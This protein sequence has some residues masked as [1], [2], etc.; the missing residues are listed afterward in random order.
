MNYK[1]GQIVKYPASAGER[2]GIKDWEIVRQHSHYWII[3]EKD[4]NSWTDLI[5]SPEG[6]DKYNK[7]GRNK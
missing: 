7:Q 1:I 2:F 3:K 4:N 5:T 6:L